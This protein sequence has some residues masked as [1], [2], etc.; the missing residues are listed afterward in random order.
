MW[1]GKKTCI[2]IMFVQQKLI[3]FKSLAASKLLVVSPSP[4]LT[5][6][7]GYL[8]HVPSQAHSHI[9]QAKVIFIY[10]INLNLAHKGN[11]LRVN[12]KQ[13]LS[14]TLVVS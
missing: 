3:T 8:C 11:D 6:T 9:C 13:V 10:N 14:I 2:Y 5:S 12:D 4:I 7:P 1:K